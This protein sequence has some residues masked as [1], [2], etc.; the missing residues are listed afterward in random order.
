MYNSGEPK[1][2]KLDMIVWLRILT[3]TNALTFYIPMNNTLA[4]Q[5]TQSFKN[6]SEQHSVVTE[7]KILLIWKH[8]HIIQ[9]TSQMLF[10]CKLLLEV[11]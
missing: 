2:W 1:C 4:F 10:L 5:V 9:H 6:M 11:F 3:I 7:Y 8:C